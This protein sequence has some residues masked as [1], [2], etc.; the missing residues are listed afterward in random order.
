WE[1]TGL[2]VE[3]TGHL[4]DF[5]D[6]NNGNNGRL[7]IGKRVGGTPWDAKVESFIIDQKT[8]KPAAESSEVVLVTPERAAQLLHR[9]DD[10]AQLM[11]VAP[12][13]VNTATRGAGSEPLKKFVAAIKPAV[14]DFLDKKSA[15]GVSRPGT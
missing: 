6:S 9:T 8:G 14:Q 7:Y 1:E 13:P 3:I 2:Q 11:A 5:E 12:I 15:A 10:L 4:G